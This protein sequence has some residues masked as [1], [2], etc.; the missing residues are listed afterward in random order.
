MKPSAGTLSGGL[1]ILVGDFN[2]DGKLDLVTGNAAGTAVVMLPGNG[3][4]TFASGVMTSIAGP[5]AAVGD[6]NGDGKPDVLWK[7]PAG[8]TLER[9]PGAR[10]RT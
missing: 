2:G 3:D 10:S 7:Q 6:F 1:G 4:G 5:P 8:S 9:C